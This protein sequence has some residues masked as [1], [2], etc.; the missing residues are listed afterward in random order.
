MKIWDIRRKGCIQTYRGHTQGVT[1]IRF[2]PDGKWVVSGGEDGLV[3]VS[4]I[5]L[6]QMLTCLKNYFID[7]LIVIKLWDLTA[8]KILHEFQQH[9]SGI[10]E[11]GFHPHEFLFTTASNDGVIKF[12][13]LETFELVSS[14]SEDQSYPKQVVKSFTFSPD[15]V[16]LCAAEPESLRVN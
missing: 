1:S 2:S 9:H 15:G 11:M 3:K 8:G 13:D 6:N 14:T 16:A 5:F 12:W 7:S 4:F 10:T